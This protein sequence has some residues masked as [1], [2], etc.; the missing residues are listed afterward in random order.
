MPEQEAF[1]VRATA[2]P[3][4]DRVRITLR[5]TLPDGVHIE[6]HRPT[7]PYL[8]P[9]VLDVDGADDAAIAYPTPVVTDLGWKGVTLTVLRGAL[10]FVVTCR[11][12]AG[13]PRVTGTFTFQPCIGGACLPPRTVAWEAPTSGSTEYS[14]LHAL[15]A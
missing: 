6:P 12:P 3:A 9:T 5:V 2:E 14:V 8:I 7:D 1:H 13:A 10:E 15:A 11:V 4:D